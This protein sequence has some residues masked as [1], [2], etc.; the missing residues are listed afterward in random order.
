MSEQTTSVVGWTPTDCTH[1]KGACQTCRFYPHCSLE[2]KE[3]K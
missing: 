1:S 3:D 2:N